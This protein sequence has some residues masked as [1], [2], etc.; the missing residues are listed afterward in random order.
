VGRY[1]Q[2]VLVLPLGDGGVEAGSGF[3]PHSFWSLARK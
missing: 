2:V 1:I 3:T